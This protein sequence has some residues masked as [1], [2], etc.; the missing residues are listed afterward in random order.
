ME[1]CDV[2]DRK[3]TSL[4]KIMKQKCLLMGG[5][6]ETD[7]RRL[8]IKKKKKD[9]NSCVFI[10]MCLINLLINLNINK[11]IYKYLS[12]CWVLFVL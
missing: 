6:S 10:H 4:I 3:V 2:T 11:Y 12:H 7:E 1:A 5:C 8:D 9:A